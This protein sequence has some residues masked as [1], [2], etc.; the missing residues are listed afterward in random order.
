VA[1]VRILPQP[2]ALEWAV[3]VWALTALT[4]LTALM[5]LMALMVMLEV[6]A[7]PLQAGSVS[8]IVAVV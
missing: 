6:W 2:A 5:A 3:E 8:A 4:A 1:A 7:L